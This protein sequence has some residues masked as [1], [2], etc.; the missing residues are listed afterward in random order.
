MVVRRCAAPWRP[1]DGLT[2]SAADDSPG[3]S[4]TAASIL[5]LLAVAA[6]SAGQTAVLAFL[7]TLVD[8]GQA[9][10]ALRI[11]DVHVASL[12]A[13]HP[14]AA[15]VFAPLWGWLADRIDYRII[16]R[17]ALV[18]LALATAPVGAVPLP[19]LY[20]L[21][22]LAGLS[23]AAIIPLALLSTNF[24]PGGRDEQA[25][26]FTWLTAFM[27][28]GD[29]FGPLLAEASASLFPRTPLLVL[30]LVIAVLALALTTG[31][32]RLPARCAA[33][34]EGRRLQAPPRVVTLVLLLVT[35]VGG[36]GLAAMHVSLLVT[37]SEGALS[38][39]A[40]AGM[41]SLCG[42]AM[43]AAQLFHTRVTWLVTAPRRLA[44]LTLALLALSLFLFRFG[45]TVVEMAGLIAVAGWS[46]ASLRL[47]TSFWISGP[48]RPSGV[49]LG[50]QH[51]AAS[52][53]QALAPMSLAVV[54]PH[55]QAAVVE[56]IG[57]LSL[58]LLA[59]L[60][61]IWRRTSTPV[62]PAGERA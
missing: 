36:G 19:M 5:L 40:I 17:T 18:V 7:P 41:L 11:H 33:R 34:P 21:R 1:E 2:C 47:V 39:E 22:L 53:G 49:M 26:R 46:S 12:T 20:G 24:A 10:L 4:Q 58:G 45:T 29:L 35:I 55:R 37:R 8:G 56:A 50:L 6:A 23:A 30:A 13:A 51:T 28:L 62:H 57:W 25:R 27:F 32:V 54:S 16:L 31:I 9:D 42:L 43:L 60:P 59:L 15:L 3:R 61:A 44:C 38:R 48:M 14:L 52:L